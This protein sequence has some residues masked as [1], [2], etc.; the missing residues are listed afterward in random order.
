MLNCYPLSLACGQC[1]TFFWAKIGNKI[2]HRKKYSQVIHWD[3]SY[4]IE[5][6][7]GKFYYLKKLLLVCLICFWGIKSCII[8]WK[9]FFLLWKSVTLRCHSLSHIHRYLFFCW[10]IIFLWSPLKNP[11]LPIELKFLHTTF[12]QKW[13]KGQMCALSWKV[14]R[15]WRECWKIWWKESAK[16]PNQLYISLWWKNAQRENGYE[17]V[18][19]K[20]MG[21]TWSMRLCVPTNSKNQ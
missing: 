13:I 4:N 10:V 1:S 20:G 17:N 12:S 3:V 2:H 18:V 11:I 5:K 9:P 7:R 6:G 19:K 21:T 15:K 14:K 8:F 16:M